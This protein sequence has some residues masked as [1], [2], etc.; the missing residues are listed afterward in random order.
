MYF[1]SRG[2]AGEELAKQLYVQYHDSN[3]VILAMSSGGVLVAEPIG[4][5]LKLPIFMLANE[6][7]D[8]P[9][10]FR[11]RVGAVDQSGDFTYDMHL[12]EGERDEVYS[13]Y[14]GHLDSE[15]AT[16][17]HKI[18]QTL[19]S[20]GFIH[21]EDLDHK[22]IMLV[23]DGMK[24]P[25]VL[26]VVINFLK[27][28]TSPRI[29]GIIPVCSIDAIDRLHIATDEIHVLSPKENYIST[30]HYYDDNNLPSD[31]EARDIIA[32]VNSLATGSVESQ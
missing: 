3:T 6:E 13:E 23:D 21:R 10:T 22:N 7:I 16:A 17:T 14:H 18:N 24:D 32:D 1:P 25:A 20:S 8:L 2:A 15:R 12:S 31:V 27:P 5:H 4:R 28:V 19:G 26:D 11:E 29:I 30:D 9:G